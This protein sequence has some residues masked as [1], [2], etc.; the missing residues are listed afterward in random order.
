MNIK[1]KNPTDTY[2]Q[3]QNNLTVVVTSYKSHADRKRHAVEF[4]VGDYV[5]VVLTKP[6][7]SAHE[8]N[9]LAARRL[10]PWKFL[11]RLIQMHIDY[12]YTW[13]H[14]MIQ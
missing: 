7:F 9:K 5:W 12:N 11:R 2:M 14:C 1:D 4:A 8:Y 3:T 13:P 6:R 10:V